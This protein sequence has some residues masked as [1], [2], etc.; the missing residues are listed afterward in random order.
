MFVD[1]GRNQYKGSEMSIAQTFAKQYNMSAVCV[2]NENDYWGQI[3]PNWS[4]N[5]LLGNLVLDK[6]DV[7]FG[8]EIKL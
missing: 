7:G 6:A 3:F 8:K 1:V 2:V 4:G 5:G